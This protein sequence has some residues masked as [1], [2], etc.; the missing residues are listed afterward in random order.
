[1]T[2]DSSPASHL[3]V[4]MTTN[5][6]QT[7]GGTNV[8]SSSQRGIE[9]YFA[10]VV[11][12]IALMGTAANGLILY[13]LFASKQHK[14]HILIVHQN[15]IELFTSSVTF[16]IYLLKFCNI[17]LTGSVG[18][19]LCAL[20]FGEGLMWMGHA[21][22]VVNLAIITVER[23]LKLKVVYPVW[24][25]TKLKN[26]MIYSAMA[27]TWMIPL[28]AFVGE[29]FPNS[30]V[31]DGVCI[32]FLSLDSYAATVIFILF[33]YLSYYIIPIF[34]FV[35][36]YWRI[37]TVI[38]RQARVMA[39]HSA[40][41]TSA[42]QTQSNQIQTNVIKT[43]ILVSALFAISWTPLYIC[44]VILYLYPIGMW[45]GM[46]Y[47]TTLFAFSNLCTNAF[48][49]ATKFDP[50]KEVL[51][52]MIPCKKTS[53]GNASSTGQAATNRTKRNARPT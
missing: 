36:C 48:I 2:E 19:W 39:G 26:W 8:T 50:V 15:I 30:K 20:L 43:M 18:Y 44:G 45:E 51:L 23:Y 47:V 35:F 52:R 21:V 16:L 38:R 11:F 14:K 27:F 28:I 4:A 3:T 12:V 33:R 10:C 34:V 6:A 7:T 9:F 42:G 17:Y 5:L 41:G 32:S 29:R 13:A 1:M 25:K 40:A 22:S 31:I 49:Y 24:S 46:C 53:E 37:L